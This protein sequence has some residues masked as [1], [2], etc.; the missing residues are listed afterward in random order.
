MSIVLELT[1]ELLYVIQYENVLILNVLDYVEELLL[2]DAYI[3]GVP[4][5]S[6]CLGKLFFL[7]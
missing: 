2:G 5:Q 4:T 6:N 1:L 7:L 3:I